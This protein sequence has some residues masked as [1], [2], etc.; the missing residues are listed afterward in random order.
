MRDELGARA[1][2]VVT[3]GDDVLVSVPYD[4]GSLQAYLDAQHGDGVSQVM[5]VMTLVTP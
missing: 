4:D 3:F 1:F 5:S 2:D